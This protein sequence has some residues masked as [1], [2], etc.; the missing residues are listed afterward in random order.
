MAMDVSAQLHH[1]NVQGIPLASLAKETGGLQPIAHSFVY[2]I[3]FD[4]SKFRTAYG[5]WEVG[6]HLGKLGLASG[7]RISEGSPQK[8][9]TSLLVSHL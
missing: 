6:D 9:D 1:M 5:E 7:L 4:F 3:V 2:M 8:K